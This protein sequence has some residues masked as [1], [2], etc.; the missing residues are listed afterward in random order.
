[1]LHLIENVNAHRRKAGMGRA[2]AM[3]LI[4]PQLCHCQANMLIKGDGG[5][6]NEDVAAKQATYIYIYIHIFFRFFFNL[7]RLD[8]LT[9]EHVWLAHLHM[10]HLCKQK[11]EER[12]IE[13][14]RERERGRVTVR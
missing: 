14:V 8:K 12:E 6:I 5:G 1:M 9:S 7:M 3:R 13:R 2:D 11:T 10:L 4:V